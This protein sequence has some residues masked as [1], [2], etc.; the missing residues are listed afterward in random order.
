ML[1]GRNGYVYVSRVEW[2]GLLLAQDAERA[3]LAVRLGY[4]RLVYC[5]PPVREHDAVA[6]HTAEH[7]HA[8]LRLL[9]G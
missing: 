9:F 4:L 3:V 1:G 5:S 2:G 7:L 8:V 6:G